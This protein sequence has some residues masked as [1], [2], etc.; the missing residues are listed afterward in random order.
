MY[1][2]LTGH[3]PF[4]QTNVSQFIEFCTMKRKAAD[5]MQQ[6]FMHNVNTNSKD[7]GTF[8]EQYVKFFQTLSELKNDYNISSDCLDMIVKFLEV[9]EEKRL[10]YGTLGSKNVKNHSFLNKIQ[11]ELLEQ[12]HI[13]PPYK[14]VLKNVVEK[15]MHDSIE[16]ALRSHGKHAWLFDFPTRSEQKNFKNW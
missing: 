1:K 6:A 5:E 16:D 9:V 12:R 10:G 15:P 11:W 8:P 13:I 7:Y 4:P 3:I 2:L 14:P